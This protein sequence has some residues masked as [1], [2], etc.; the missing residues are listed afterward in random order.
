MEWQAI[1]NFCTENDKVISAI[2]AIATVIVMYQTVRATKAS[3]KSALVAF[4]ALEYSQRIS[5]R[6][7]FESRYSL[8]LDQHNQHLKNVCDFLASQEGGTFKGLVEENKLVY[9][10]SKV[11]MGH[12]VISPYMRILYHLL[13]HID[14]NYYENGLEDLVLI[15][16]KKEY[17]SPLRSL[18]RNDVLYLVALNS[19]ITKTNIDGIKK[20]NGY[21]RYQKLLHDFDFFEH[22]IF[23]NW[24]LNQPSGIGLN[25]IIDFFNCTY[26]ETMKDCIYSSIYHNSYNSD[27]YFELVT[28]RKPTVTFSLLYTYK[29]PAQGCVHKLFEEAEGVLCRYIKDELKNC[30]M[31]RDTAW[32]ELNKLVGLSL[33][34]D[35]STKILNSNIKDIE[36]VKD[37]IDEYVSSN[38]KFNRMTYDHITFFDDSNTN[39]DMMGVAVESK[40]K[41][42]L[43]NSNLLDLKNSPDKDEKITSLVGFA[44]KKINE[45]RAQ[46]K[47]LRYD[48]P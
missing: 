2:A 3:R 27:E 11:L 41:S 42:Y 15:Q 34:Y 28:T 6:E 10:A 32:S 25:K 29:N 8:L 44:L 38:G 16:K 18:I 48:A 7:A 14:D 4:K 26:I 33:G 30:Q 22:A 1:I 31:N 40:I 36:D 5:L 9:D 23:Y 45:Q 37:I 21:G 20:D 47:Q 17:T 35:S 43:Y 24:K 39:N 19:I 13:K 46:L 12:A